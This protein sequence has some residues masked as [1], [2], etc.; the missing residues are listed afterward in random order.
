MAAKPQPKTRAPKNDLSKVTAKSAQGYRFVDK[1]PDMEYVVAAIGNSG[2][3][4]EQIEKL[5][6]RIGRRVSAA[7]VTGWMF[8]ATKRPQNYTLTS[9]M[10]ALGFNRLWT[11]MSQNEFERMEAAAAK[12]AKAAEKTAK[13][14]AKAAV[15]EAKTGKPTGRKVTKDAVAPKPTRARRKEVAA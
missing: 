13:A 15:T 5:T 3:S 1:D 2:K 6:T 9:V 12:A 10:Y 7:A 8:G 14:E 4:P 11:P